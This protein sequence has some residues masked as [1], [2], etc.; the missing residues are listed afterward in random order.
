MNTLDTVCQY[1]ASLRALHGEDAITQLTLSEK[2]YWS[3]L[4]DAEALSRV[5]LIG[6]GTVQ[7]MCVA[8]E[9]AGR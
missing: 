3:L 5:Q 7:V 6:T 4:R 1:I 8:I 9:K 2:A